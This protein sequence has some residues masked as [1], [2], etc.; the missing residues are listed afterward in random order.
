MKDYM[1][2]SDSEGLIDP[3]TEEAEIGAGDDDDDPRFTPS[4][5]EGGKGHGSGS[6]R[7]RMVDDDERVGQEREDK[8]IDHAYKRD[9]KN[10][11]GTF[12]SFFATY[13]G[14]AVAPPATSTTYHG[15]FH[16]PPWHTME[17]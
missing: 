9:K 12:L 16:G 13:R 3:T 17:H 11:G 2:V 6:A 7:K 14:I 4:E 15:T 10:E 1:A 5:M 8:N